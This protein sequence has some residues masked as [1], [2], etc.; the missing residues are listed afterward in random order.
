MNEGELLQDCKGSES[1]A[2]RGGQGGFEEL[3]NVIRHATHSISA[4]NFI[5]TL[6]PSVS[7]AEK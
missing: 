1:V 2:P 3:N 7:F 4:I 6:S 5:P